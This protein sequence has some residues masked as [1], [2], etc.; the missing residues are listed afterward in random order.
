M[1]DTQQLSLYLTKNTVQLHYE[2]QMVTTVLA[3]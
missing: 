3:K 2:D 1:N